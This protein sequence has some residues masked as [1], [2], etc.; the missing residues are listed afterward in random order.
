MPM[1]SSLHRRRDAHGQELTVGEALDRLIKDDKP[2]KP[3]KLVCPHAL[4]YAHALSVAPQRRRRA[5]SETMPQALERVG[6]LPMAEHGANVVPWETAMFIHLRGACLGAWWYDAK[7]KTIEHATNAPAF[8][9]SWL[10]WP[11]TVP[12]PFTRRTLARKIPGIVFQYPANDAIRPARPQA[13]SWRDWKRQ[14]RLR[15][16][17]HY[18]GIFCQFYERWRALPTAGQYER[19]HPMPGHVLQTLVQAVCQEFQVEVDDALDS[20]GHSMLRTQ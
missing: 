5:P 9:W 4:W 6:R 3:G 17:R 13:L 11:F 15:A 2:L 16:G 20:L 8:P 14:E 10:V 12:Q 18:L 7:T 19:R 1:D